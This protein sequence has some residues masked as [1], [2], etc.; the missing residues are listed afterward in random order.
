MRLN[1][2]FRVAAQMTPRSVVRVGV[3]WI[4]AAKLI[5]LLVSL[6]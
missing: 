4:T 2:G 1:L 6:L 5:E 3:V